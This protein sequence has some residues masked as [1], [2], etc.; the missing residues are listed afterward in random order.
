MIDEL[1]CNACKESLP[2]ANFSVLR[3]AKRGYQYRCRACVKA[4]DAKRHAAN[5]EALNKRSRE[6]K[7]KNR[8][9]VNET[10][11]RWR[12]DNREAYRAIQNRSGAKQYIKNKDC[13]EHQLKVRARQKVNN[14][15]KAGRLIR[16]PCED[17][18]CD[19]GVHA[20]HPDY[21]APLDVKWLCKPCHDKEHVKIESE[22]QCK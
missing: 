18:G 21:N 16:L 10:H 1:S 4:Y 22:A 17:C 7:K 2:L 20:H 8:D 6:W 3:S 9:I 15:I 11:D 14:E 19:T 5:P 12:K 13:Q